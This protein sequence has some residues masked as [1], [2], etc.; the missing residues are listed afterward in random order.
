LVKRLTERYVF[1]LFKDNGTEFLTV[2]FVRF[3]DEIPTVCTLA[4]EYKGKEMEV[5]TELVLYMRTE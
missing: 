2:W 3:I 4:K 5:K 1:P